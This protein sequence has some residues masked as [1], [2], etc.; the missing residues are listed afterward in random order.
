MTNSTVDGLGAEEI[1]QIG[2]QA[3]NL[4]LAGSINTTLGITSAATTQGLNVI[5]T[6]AL[7]GPLANLGNAVL[8]GSADIPTVYDN[9]GSPYAQGN[10]YTSFTAETVITGGMWVN[11]SGAVGGAAVL[12]RAA[13]V[14][15]TPL[16]VATATAGS[17]ATVSILTRGFHYFTT[18]AT[19]N[20]GV[21]FS[22]GGGAALNNVGLVVSG[23]P[24]GHVNA[25]GTVI[26]GGTSGT[27]N[28]VLV[29]LW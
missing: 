1:G 19:L 21:S 26:A 13:A 22:M 28:N 29:Y 15:T 25:R 17:N 9:T 3:S 20:N 16:G 12:A 7:S 8:T 18:E 5:G 2:S 24:G 10:V 23:A 4:F 27:S 14:D 6:T 11:V